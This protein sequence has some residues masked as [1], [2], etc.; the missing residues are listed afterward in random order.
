MHPL[1]AELGQNRDEIYR[2]L[3]RVVDR[4]KPFLLRTELLDILE[5]HARGSVSW[6]EADSAWGSMVRKCQEAS[7]DGA[8]VYFAQR[9]QI[10][11]WSYHRIHLS[12]CEVDDVDVA[13]YFDFKERLVES[14]SSD[15]PDN[16][17]AKPLTPD[18]VLEIDLSP[19]NRGFPK[20]QET[21]SIGQGVSFLNRR[22]CSEL[23]QD[24]GTEKLLDFLRVHQHR[25]QQLMLNERVGDVANAQRALRRAQ[26]YLRDVAPGTPWIDLAPRMSEF[27]FERGWGKDAERSLDTLH[28]LSDILEAPGPDILE[29]F[30]ARIPMIFSIVILTPHGYFGQS[31]VLGMPDTG[32]QVVY[33]LDQAR[34]LEKEMYERLEEQGIDVDPQI[35]VVTRLI[36]EAKET[37]CDQPRERIEGTRNAEIVRVPF[38][39][40]SGD[41][42]P[43]WISRFEIWPYLERFSYEVERE[44]LSELGERPGIIVGNYS[45][46]NLVASLI[47]RR[48]QVTQCTIAH[49]LE[50]TKYLMSDLF[51][52][53]ND[54]QYHFSCQYTAD[55][56][57]M[58]TS[59][60]IIT[61]TFQEIAGTADSVG[62]YESYGSFTMPGLQRVVHGVDV[63]DPKFNIV[64]PGADPEVYFPYS[65]DDHRLKALHPQLLDL[66][67]GEGNGQPHRGQLEDPSKPVIFTMA[68]LDRIKNLTGLVDWYGRNAKLREVANLFVIG[69]HIDPD[70]SG[71]REERAQIERM[72]ELIDGHDLEGNLRWV[73]AQS[74]RVVNGEL[75]R[76][77]ADMR[78]VFVQPALFEAYG[79]TVIEAL[80]SGLPTFA[81]CYGGPSEII[82]DGVSGFHIDPNAGA[83]VSD[84]LLAFFEKCRDDPGHWDTI[85]RN[86]IE[87][88]EKNYT[89]KLY[90]EK[91]MTLARV[92]GFWKYVTNLERE[93]TRRYLELF[94]GLQYRARVEKLEKS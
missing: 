1:A 8:W 88:I 44:V 74:D 42:V 49:A 57:A 65:D 64:S 63:F 81:T 14:L 7:T 75:Y 48:L 4:D 66:I 62:Q 52:K 45:D 31:N 93:E 41:V 16:T 77:I 82:E 28:L 25:G 92:Y 94:Y 17:I 32:G 85:S 60:F 61:S 43:Q 53:E 33:I 36:P 46:G 23:F 20:M 47:S 13:E 19:F 24:G 22:L 11:R 80:S 58:N 87:R 37:T 59:D 39:D 71:D 3:Q 30:L 76:I 90:G 79:L 35:L 78:G 67:H 26:A 86:A 54:D 27:G 72:H 70:L 56:I 50:K 40:R 55:L 21:R 29:K 34:A 91:M 69:G 18:P 10:G 2:L 83:A 9:P 68:R 51:W 38:R 6:S 5:D 15:A 12:S 84:K 89:W 73:S